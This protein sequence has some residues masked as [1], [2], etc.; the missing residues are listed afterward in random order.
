MS[1]ITIETESA[2]RSRETPDPMREVR[3]RFQPPRPA[4]KTIPTTSLSMAPALPRITRL[5]ALAIKLEGLRQQCPGLPGAEWARRGGVSRSRITQILNLLHLAPHI[6]ERLL[7]L[8][9]LTRGREVISENCLRRRA[10]ESH[11][12]RQRERF[13]ELLT[14]RAVASGEVSESD[15]T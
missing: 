3:Y 9:P 13:E 2:P 14:R 5:M 10:G 1:N 7:W 11:G 15:K 4:R 6:Q 12:E 8:P